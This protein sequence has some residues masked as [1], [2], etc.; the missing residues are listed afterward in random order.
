MNAELYNHA[1]IIAIP[2]KR[3]EDSTL[4]PQPNFIV[5]EEI[6]GRVIK[7]FIDSKTGEYKDTPCMAIRH[8]I[9]FRE[10]LEATETKSEDVE[11]RILHTGVD[12]LPYNYVPLLQSHQFVAE[13]IAHVN[14]ILSLFSFRGVLSGFKL[15]V[16][17]NI[18]DEIIY[19]I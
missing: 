15:E 12:Y 7:P 16:D 17:T 1:G 8:K 6:S 13:N 11:T 9:V 5:I 19:N 18:I 3:Q 10:V 2:L 14:A 4:N